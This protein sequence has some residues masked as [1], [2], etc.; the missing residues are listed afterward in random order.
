MKKGHLPTPPD[1][2]PEAPLDDGVFKGL[3]AD[4][5]PFEGAPHLA[6]AV[7]GGGDSLG[8]AFLAARWAERRG[9]R[10]TA[11]T[12]DHGLRP[13]S[14]AEARRVGEWLE[15]KGI[16]HRVLEWLGPKPRSGVQEAARLARYGLMSAWCRE[17]G[18]LHLLLAHTM[19]D[20]AE[21]L[22]LRLGSG[23]G[24]DGLAAMAA[25]RETPDLRLLR[26]L[27]GVRKTALTSL[28]AA[29]GQEWIE[30]PSNRDP[31][32]ARTRIRQAMSDGGLEVQELAL[33]AMRFGRARAALEGAAS[34]WLARGA[35]V[36]PA[37]FARLDRAG[38]LAAPAEVSFRALSRVILAIGGRGHGPRTGK[39]E[40]LLGS[41]TDAD[42]ASR[43][44]GGCRIVGREGE[45][46]VCRENRG[47][48]EPISVRPGLKLTWDRRFSIAFGENLPETPGKNHGTVPQ[49]LRLA[50]LGEQGWS[51]IVQIR[52]ELR[53]GPVPGPARE[54]LP[55][56]FDGSGVLLVPHLDYRRPESRGF[57]GERDPHSPTVGGPGGGPVGGDELAEIRFCPPNT[58]SSVGFFLNNDPGILSH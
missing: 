34:E 28:L 6:V 47:L 2:S 37:G 49:G 16:R 30:D 12:V 21:T 55:A 5:G 27:L 8:L 32:F 56:L 38:L 45:I 9:G 17:A 53:T 29:Q 36:H 10:V 7:S 51:E 41:L 3:M 11:L 15:A 1:G 26:P 20:Q 35:R 24:P 13:D 46:L 40:R 31:A 48:P 23:S 33:S 42:G 58:L 4:L 14:A 50:G 52:P 18:I 19:D 54:S 39:L 22:L 57:S 25:V 44:L 43:T